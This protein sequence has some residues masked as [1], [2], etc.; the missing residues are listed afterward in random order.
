MPFKTKKHKKN[1]RKRQ[2]FISDQGLAAYTS[3]KIDLVETKKP[4]KTQ[5][6]ESAATYDNYNYLRREMI[7]ILAISSLIIGLQ[8]IIKFS[9]ITI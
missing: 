4:K 8:V 3:K 5:K 6:T 9:N 1:A 7:T 2:V